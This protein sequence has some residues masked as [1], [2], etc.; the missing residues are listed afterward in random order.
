MLYLHNEPVVL[1]PSESMCSDGERAGG[2]VLP[3]PVGYC[4][5]R[6]GIRTKNGTLYLATM[7]DQSSN[8]IHPS[9]W[10]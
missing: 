10:K 7:N 4:S 5:T 2:W 3:R 1:P 6:V 9:A 8:A